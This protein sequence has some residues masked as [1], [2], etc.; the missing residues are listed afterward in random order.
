[1]LVEIRIPVE[2]H[3]STENYPVFSSSASR[4]AGVAEPAQ[5]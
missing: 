3:A 5:S 2:V 1:M 4:V